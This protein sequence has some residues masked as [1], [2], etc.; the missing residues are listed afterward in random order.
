M[1]LP[2]AAPKNHPLTHVRLKAMADYLDVRV[3]EFSDG[4]P[5]RRLA[6]TAIHSLASHLRQAAIFVSDNTGQQLWAEQG[7][8]TTVA[9]LV[10]R[11]L[12]E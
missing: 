9:D 8:K 5:D 1:Y 2:A 6:T 4:R 11:H 10:P 12:G 7:R 3:H